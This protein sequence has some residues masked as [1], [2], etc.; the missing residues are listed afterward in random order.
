MAGGELQ[1]VALDATLDEVLAHLA[2]HEGFTIAGSIDKSPAY[3]IS[4]R[5]RGRLHDL[6]V[7]LM[8]DENFSLVFSATAPTKIERIV[9]AG[10]PIVSS[11]ANKRATIDGKG[12]GAPSGHTIEQSAN[13]P[14]PD[15]QPPGVP[16]ASGGNM[17]G[18]IP[19]PVPSAGAP[20]TESVPTPSPMVQWS[21]GQFSGNAVPTPG[22]SDFQA[23]ASHPK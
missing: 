22:V 8:R 6:L 11:A 7:R 15:A 20:A 2:K 9:L 5:L 23:I 13:S 18:D 10:V 16:V 12:G 17:Q 21:V 19:I 14:L 3:R 1:I 4:V